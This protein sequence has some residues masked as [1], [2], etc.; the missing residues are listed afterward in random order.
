MQTISQQA[1][2]LLQALGLCINETTHTIEDL[3][4]KA[5]L[6]KTALKQAMLELEETGYILTWEE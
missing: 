5:H 3:K 6:S 1:A 2:R 4:G